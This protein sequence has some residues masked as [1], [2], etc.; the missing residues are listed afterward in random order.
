M[1]SL[2]PYTQP[3]NYTH[4]FEWKNDV[5]KKIQENNV[6]FYDAEDSQP[7]KQALTQYSI[8]EYLR[9]TPSFSKFFE[10]LVKS[11]MVKALNICTFITY[12]TVFAVENENIPDELMKNLDNHLAK[13]IIWCSTMNRVL[14]VEVF[15]DTLAAYYQTMDRSNDVFITRLKNGIFL[16]NNIPILRKNIQTV[17]GLIHVV[18]SLRKPLII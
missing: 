2:G 9:R 18:G 10:I 14:P 4:M 11:E 12:Y 8:S 13:R 6:K 16:D 17:N 7:I 15:G 3:Q 5:Y 1:T